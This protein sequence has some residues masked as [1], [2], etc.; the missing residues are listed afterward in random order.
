[1]EVIQSNNLGEKISN[2]YVKNGRQNLPWRYSISPYRVWISEIMLQQTQVN[3][4]IAYFERFMAKYPDLQT[5]K[6]ASEDDIYNLWSGLGYYRRASF[7]FQAKELIH[8]KFKGEMPDNYDDLVSL[9]GVGKSTAG[10]ILSIAFN[11][12]YPILDANVKKVISRIF[13]KKNFEEKIFWNL[14]E[15]LLD[16]KNI[17]NFQQGVMDVGAKLCLPKNPRCNLCPVSKDCQSNLRNEFP[18]LSKKSVK[19]KKEFLEFQLIQKNQK[20]FMTKENKLGYWANLWMPPVLI[21]NHQKAEIIHK[22][23]HR[24][25]NINFKNSNKKPKNIQGKWFHKKELALI[26]IPKPIFNRLLI[27]G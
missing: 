25:L 6:K 3:T 11:K 16:K 2:W 15:D 23:S 20:Y 14:S 22:L 9:P 8:A 7:I 4:A 19:R 18:L 21:A 10:A 26:A 5:I 17:F 1:M 27:D 13:F 24:E 12:P